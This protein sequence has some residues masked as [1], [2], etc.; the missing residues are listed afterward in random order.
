MG[1][2]RVPMSQKKVQCSVSLKQSTV[3]TIDTLT[4]RRSRWIEDAIE[5]KIKG[6]SV[7]DDLTLKDILKHA[8]HPFHKIEMSFEERTVLERIYH[9][10][11][12]E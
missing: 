6:H 12:S 7:V 9:R 5:L 10:L 11:L 3:E 8:L 4:S 1:R 2:K